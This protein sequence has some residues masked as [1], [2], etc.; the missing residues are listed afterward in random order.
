[1]P[2]HII[3]ERERKSSR[4]GWWMS[5]SVSVRPSA[6]PSVRLSVHLFSSLPPFPFLSVV[7]SGCLCAAGSVTRPKHPVLYL[8]QEADLITVYCEGEKYVSPR[9]LLALSHYLTLLTALL[10]PTLLL[11]VNTKCLRATSSHT[12]FVRGVYMLHMLWSVTLNFGH[13]CFLV[14]AIIYCN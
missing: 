11:H 12:A 7:L 14:F 5:V 6:R 2:Y 9:L 4:K 10:F 8:N 1:M 13:Q 3:C